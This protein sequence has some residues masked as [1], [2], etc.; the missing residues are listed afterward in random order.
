MGHDHKN[1]RPVR[2][3]AGR[4]GVWVWFHDEWCRPLRIWVY[5]GAW[6]VV[7]RRCMA[8]LSSDDERYDDGWPT[9]QAALD[10]AHAHCAAC[11]TAGARLVEAAA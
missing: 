8:G 6:R 7:C 4:P 10:A 3:I 11:P 9:W 2:G 1:G 5:R